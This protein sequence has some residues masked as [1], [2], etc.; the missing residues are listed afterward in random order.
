MIMTTADRSGQEVRGSSAP[1]KVRPVE[2]VYLPERRLSRSRGTLKCVAPQAMPTPIWKLNRPRGT[3]FGIL[4]SRAHS[5]G[6]EH[7]NAVQF[8]HLSKI[9]FSAACKAALIL[10]HLRTVSGPTLQKPEFSRS[11]SRPMER[12]RRWPSIDIPRQQGATLAPRESLRQGVLKCPSPLQRRRLR[13]AGLRSFS[14]GRVPGQET[15]NADRRQMGRRPQRPDLFGRGP[16]NG[17][18]HRPR[19]GRGQGGYRSCRRRRAPR[20]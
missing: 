13:Y 1:P 19:P 3:E 2:A 15:S 7:P 6:L 18:N 4:G 9:E 20:F 17:R 11:Q 8:L 10:K 16:R 12:F 5:A 14:R